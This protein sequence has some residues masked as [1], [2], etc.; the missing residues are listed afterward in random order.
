MDESFEER[1]REFSYRV[2]SLPLE[3]T[4]T[5]VRAHAKDIK[6]SAK[7]YS[8]WMDG[9]GNTS[10]IWDANKSF[11]SLGINPMYYYGSYLHPEMRD[12]GIKPSLDQQRMA[13]RLFLQD[14][15]EEEIQLLHYLKYRNTS[16]S[17]HDLLQICIADAHLPMDDRVKSTMYLC[18]LYRDASINHETKWDSEILP[19]CDLV[20]NATMIG[21]RAV[22]GGVTG[23]VAIPSEKDFY[24]GKISK[25]IKFCR[26]RSKK[27]KE[28][29]AA[30]ARCRVETLN[31]YES[32]FSYPN[33]F[34]LTEIIRATGMPA[35]EVL[36][37]EMYPHPINA[38]SIGKVSKERSELIN[39]VLKDPDKDVTW[40]SF[41]ILGQ[42]GGSWHCYLH[43][44][45]MIAGLPQKFRNDFSGFVSV[46]YKMDSYMDRIVC[47]NQAEPQLDI[48]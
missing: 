28:E 11:A 36:Y 23:Y 6:F 16:I 27:S 26:Y 38:L 47:K 17:W 12:V 7:T 10:Y 15:T 48:V 4:N 24:V 41:L 9:T 18:N 45:A 39:D 33:F 13:L 31:N 5:S 3:V 43:K 2:Y 46:S 14:T 22:L 34:R 20:K 42:H 35:F 30:F 29:I 25:I 8:G 21:H 1:A 37:G 32:D 40:L 19:N 44:M